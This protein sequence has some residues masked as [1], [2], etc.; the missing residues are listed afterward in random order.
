MNLE[1]RF[2]MS[3]TIYPTGTTIY[4]PDKCFNGFTLF[5]PMGK[6]AVLVDMNG[7]EVNVW[8]DITGMPVK[9]LPGGQIIG[10]LGTRNPKFMSMEFSELVQV[11]WDGNIVWKFD[12]LEYIEDPGEEPRWMARQK[13]DY[14]REGNPVGYYVPGMEC[15]TD[16]GNTLILCHRDVEN[17]KVSGHP[18]VDDAIV[19]IDWEGNIV[20][21]WRCNEHFRE[22]HF[23][24]AAKN[25]IYRDP[26]LRF[27]GAN[28][29]GDWMHFNNFNVLGPNKWYDEGDER[30]HPDNIIWCARQAN[31]TAIISK[32]T[33]KIV[34]QLGPDYDDKKYRF[35]GQIIGQHH[36]HMIPRGLPGEGNIL[37]FDNGGVAGYGLPNAMSP[38]G[39][40]NCR[41]DYSRVLEI[42]PVTLS[43]EWQYTTVDA[44]G[45]IPIDTGHFY[46]PFMSSAQRLPNGN[47]MITEASSGR[48]FEVTQ[49]KE[50]VWEYVNPYFYSGA[51]PLNGGQSKSNRLYRAYRVPYS[52]CPQAPIGEQKEIIPPELSDFRVAGAAPR[53]SL[54]ETIV[55]GTQSPEKNDLDNACIITE[56]EK[57]LIEQT[58]L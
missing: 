43:V 2:T 48:I 35:I 16:S 7:Q 1:R 52:Y 12:H 49:E 5:A 24:E 46:S 39:F 54:K 21:E 25:I 58:V 29:R 18:I 57:E 26:N 38:S 9:M 36:S 3:A 41:R 28:S 56:E 50:L 31:I 13:G 37:I 11:D 20:W 32:E 51:R 42:N 30:F 22:L 53:G 15:K 6:G 23:S 40:Q 8:K 17:P 10:S 14:Q 4:K 45:I 33:G 27:T 34:W 19:E 44:G 55:E 47:T